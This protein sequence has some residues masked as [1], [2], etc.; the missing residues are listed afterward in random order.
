MRLILAATA[1][2]SGCR[3]LAYRAYLRTQLAVVRLLV[4]QGEPSTSSP[5]AAALR[6]A[7]P[8]P[9]G[10]WSGRVTTGRGASQRCS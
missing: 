7:A 10:R 4:E 3:L 9:P 2:T 8:A 1:V 6:A 5:G